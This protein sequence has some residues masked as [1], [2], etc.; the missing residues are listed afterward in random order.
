MG[1]VYPTFDSYMLY[2]SPNLAN[3]NSLYFIGIWREATQYF[4]D[5]MM[6]ISIIELLLF[7]DLLK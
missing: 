6:N 5:I 2:E 1:N 7:F 4:I 3:Q